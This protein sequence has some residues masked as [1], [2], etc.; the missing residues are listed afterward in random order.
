MLPDINLLPK[1]SR[2]GSWAYIFFLIGLILTIVALIGL[3]VYYFYLRGTLEDTNAQLREAEDERHLLELQVTQLETSESD[4]F[5]T[6]YAYLDQQIAP[7]SYL[8]EELNERL[9]EHSYFYEFAYSEHTAQALIQ[10]ETM[11]D[12]AFY[13][14]ELIRSDYIVDSIVDELE[15]GDVELIEYD[16]EGEE[17]D[18][19]P[20][21]DYNLIPR[22]SV[23]YIMNIDHAYL[24]EQGESEE[25]KSDE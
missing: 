9:P 10:F 8:I 20:E 18:E 15:A 2:Q 24:K 3:L 12:S 13:V 16:E 1:Y 21:I 17:I 19:G 25:E 7:V 11:N 6:A 14:E 5:H 23:R 22:Y 4:T